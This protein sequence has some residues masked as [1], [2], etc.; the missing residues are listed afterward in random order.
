MLLR[1][2]QEVMLA[3]EPREFAAAIA[4][5][6]SDKELWQQLSDN[7][8]KHIKEH[9]SPEVVNEQLAKALAELIHGVDTQCQPHCGK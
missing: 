2:G 9:F 4:Q 7:A 3:D 8:Y 5:V 1:S 6:Y